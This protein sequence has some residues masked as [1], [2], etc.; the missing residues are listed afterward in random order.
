VVVVITAAV[1]SK[2]EVEGPMSRW[3]SELNP[4][5]P[6]NELVKYLSDRYR[7]NFRCVLTERKKYVIF[8]PMV[9]DKLERCV[10]GEEYVVIILD[11]KDEDT[12]VVQGIFV[13]KVGMEGNAHIVTRI[14]TFRGVFTKRSFT[15]EHYIEYTDRECRTPTEGY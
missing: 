6:F 11:Y 12:H 13:K 3:R 15:G 5:K 14:E 7:I 4:D 1:M 10:T 2:E 8:T 9:K